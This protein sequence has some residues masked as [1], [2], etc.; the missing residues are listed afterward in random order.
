MP[1]IFYARSSNLFLSPILV[2]TNAHS[3]AQTSHEMNL[4]VTS[5]NIGSP[6]LA[7][8]LERIT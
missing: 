1:M 3:W 8:G 2:A 6:K 5:L 7:R 4:A